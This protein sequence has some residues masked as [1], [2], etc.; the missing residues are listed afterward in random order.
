MLGMAF[1]CSL[2]YAWGEESEEPQAPPP[3]ARTVQVHKRAHELPE[4]SPFPAP[5]CTQPKLNVA[6]G[7]QPETR[8]LVLYIVAT[9]GVLAA[10]DLTLRLALKS[11]R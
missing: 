2:K 11:K 7:V 5:R 3:R 1:G 6:M 9:L 10:M 8:R 4:V